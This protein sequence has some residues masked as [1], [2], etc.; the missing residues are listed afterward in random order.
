MFIAKICASI[1][2][3][4]TYISVL[5]N[6]NNRPLREARSTQHLYLVSGPAVVTAVAIFSF[7]EEE[8]GEGGEIFLRSYYMDLMH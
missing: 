3:Y 6:D 1:Y 8:R 5:I 4:A 7:R 2:V